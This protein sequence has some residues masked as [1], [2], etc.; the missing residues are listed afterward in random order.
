LREDEDQAGYDR[1]SA[2]KNLLVGQHHDVQIC[3]LLPEARRFLPASLAAS[4]RVRD[5]AMQFFASRMKGQGLVQVTAFNPLSWRRTQWL[6]A[7]LSFTQK[8]E[9]KSIRVLR[10]DRTDFQAYCFLLGS[11]GASAPAE[12]CQNSSACSP[13]APIKLKPHNAPAPSPSR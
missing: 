10:G 5:G 6:E 7:E 1:E 11:P 13:D 8:G 2:W 9:A 3:G 12:P 4:A